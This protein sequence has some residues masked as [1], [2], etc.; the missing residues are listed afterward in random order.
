[1][2]ENQ[3]PNKENTDDGVRQNSFDEQIMTM[4]DSTNLF[5]HDF[6]SIYDSLSKFDQKILISEFEQWYLKGLVNSHYHEKYIIPRNQERDN[7]F[8]ESTEYSLA[9]KMNHY[10][11][12]LLKGIDLKD[13]PYYYPA[14][15]QWLEDKI[16]EVQ[17]FLQ[18]ERRRLFHDNPNKTKISV[19]YQFPQHLVDNIFNKTT[20]DQS[21]RVQINVPLIIFENHFKSVLEPL[22][23][24]LN[25][26]NYLAFLYNTFQF[27]D[28][29]TTPAAL[30]LKHSGSREALKH[31]IF[32]LYNEFKVV[33]GTKKIV[34]AKSLILNFSE[35]RV[36]FYKENL[37]LENHIDSLE[38]SIRKR[39]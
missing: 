18:M 9:T 2:T 33:H 35:D 7:L 6:F 36:R 15:D 10:S 32:D 11:L 17:R 25:P 23:T 37:N 24:L 8:I 4:L 39:R 1:M 31:L 3:L 34:F 20:L 30:K 19:E 5:S 26:E 14:T 13:H 12:T 28:N 38:K 22:K 16:V 21:F 29:P 27:R